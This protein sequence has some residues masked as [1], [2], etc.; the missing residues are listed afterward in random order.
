MKLVF[1]IITLLLKYAFGIV[2][3]GKSGMGTCS[4]VFCLP[5]D[6]DKLVAPFTESGILDI[7][8]ELEISQ[9]LAFDD[10]KCHFHQ[11]SMSS[12][13]SQRS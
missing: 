6:Y 5:K 7:A 1:T 10:I 8:F 13:C 2:N 3:E 9:I 12:F 4:N 11:R